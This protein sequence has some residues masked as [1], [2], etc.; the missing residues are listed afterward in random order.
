M[1]GA[2]LVNTST[3]GMTGQLDLELDLH[4]LPETAVVNDI[5]Y[6]PLE[7]PL[8]RKAKTRGNSLSM[9]LA[10]CYIRPGQGLRH[11]SVKSR[12]FRTG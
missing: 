3:L 8:L 5:V 12:R 11:G 4:D 2:A 9:D 10:C 6:S 7:T 1:D